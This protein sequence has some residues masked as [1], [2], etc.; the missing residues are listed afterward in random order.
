MLSSS[1]GY[2]Q[3]RGGPELFYHLQRATPKRKNNTQPLVLVLHGATSNSQV[4]Q[5]LADE[6]LAQGKDVLRVD[7]PGQGRS[8]MKSGVV[9]ASFS[10]QEAWLAQLMTDLG[11]QRVVIYGHSMGTGPAV[12]TAFHFR[13]MGGKVQALFL[14]DPYVM[15]IEDYYY[16]N[17]DEMLSTQISGAVKGF[18][19]MQMLG[20][21]LL[22][23]SPLFF[24]GIPQATFLLGAANA[25]LGKSGEL[26]TGVAAEIALPMIKHL[27]PQIMAYKVRQNP[28][29]Y[30]VMVACR[31]VQRRWPKGW[32]R[33][34]IPFL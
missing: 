11:F 1:Q 6:L 15:P 25:A 32:L 19:K 14:D 9:R 16:Q 27:T 33:L 22:S 12:L 3:P 29:L 7:L 10:Q 21:A 23:F 4:Y 8:L 13:E 24:T 17:Q 5:P 26:L 28:S 30:Q 20:G 2:Y 34:L 31:P 18:G